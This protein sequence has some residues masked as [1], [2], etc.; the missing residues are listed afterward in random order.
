MSLKHKLEAQGMLWKHYRKTFRTYWA[1]RNQVG[2][3]LFRREE[4][5]F[6]P[7]ALEIQEKPVSPTLRM[8]A[9]VIITV[10]LIG[11]GWTFFA[12]LD[13]F[14]SASGEIIPHERTKTVASID[15]AS[16]KAL[17]VSEGQLVKKGDLL[18]ELDTTAVDAEHDKAKSNVTEARLKIARSQALIAAID[19]RRAPR[20]SALADIPPHRII[21]VQEH[22][23]G[24]YRDFMARVQRLEGSIARYTESLALITRRV[25]DYKEL[26][27]NHDVSMHT[28]LEKEQERADIEGQLKDTKN[29]LTGLIADAKRIAYDEQEEAAKTIGEAR[30]DVTRNAA[31]SKLLRLVAPITGT[32]QQLEVYTVGGIVPAAQPLMKIVPKEDHVEVVAKIENRDVGF[33]EVGQ[34]AAVKVDAFDYAKFGFIQGKVVNISQD[35]VKDEKRGLLYSLTIALDKSTIQV[36]ENEVPLTAGMTVSVDIKTGSRR[37]IEYFLSP[38]VQHKRESLHER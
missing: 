4:A 31:H 23:N 15:M 1:L 18:I 5:E 8:T 37:V 20:L 38:F 17:H 16:V 7:A 26:A 9:K 36:K 21:E 34:L 22:L 30:Q 10:L 24:Q 28:Y 29:Q 35:A 14:V 6:L 3:D 27:N 19:S 33:V 2:S 25:A 11:L 13:I 32:V 12:T